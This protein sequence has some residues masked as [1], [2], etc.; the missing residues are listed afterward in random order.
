MKKIFFLLSI[1]ILVGAC[2]NQD[3]GFDDFEFQAVY[4]PYQTPVRTLMLGDEV[5]G[6]NT[7]DREHAFSIGAAIGGMYVNEMDREVTVEY[8]PELAQDILDENT[9][10]TLALMPPEYYTLTSD[11]ITIPEGSFFGKMRVELKD[12]FFEDPDAI[13]LKYV[14]PLVITDALGDSILSGKGKA[15][16]D[17]LDR[18][19]GGHWDIEPKDYTL[20][21][22]NYI[23]PLHGVY[24]LRGQSINTTAVPNDTVFYSERF[25]DDN[26][27]VALGTQSMDQVRMPTVG[28]VNKGGIYSM[29][30]TFDEDAQTV[31]VS[32]YDASSVLVS[33][34][35]TYYTKDDDEAESYTD[36]KH[37]TIYLD[38]TFED[39]GDTYQVND[40]L[41]FIDTG[42]KF[43]EYKLNVY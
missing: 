13:R 14:I 31:A 42:I 26:D 8:A 2:S 15:T 1:L 9:G 6:D 7:I 36:F 40:S 20:F 43:R 25:L 39:G 41:V 23:N 19:V 17:T 27:M 11:R 30:L 10:D 24:L 22:V 28:G 12:A 21:A 4:F 35:G 5:V 29:M 32:Q 34:T 3:I 37:R 16:I 38:Y 33:G 18:R